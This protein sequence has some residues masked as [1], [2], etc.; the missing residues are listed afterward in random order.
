[1]FVVRKAKDL[2]GFYKEQHLE[3][4]TFKNLASARDMQK[5]ALEQDDNESKRFIY[6]L[7]WFWEVSSS[8]D[9]SGNVYK[10]T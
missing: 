6:K 2:R 9:S 10:N 8:L 1:M 5:A 3:D 4:I 7:S